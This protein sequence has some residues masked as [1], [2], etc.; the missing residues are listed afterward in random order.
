MK[1]NKEQPGFFPIIIEQVLNASVEKVWNAITNGEEMN[2]WY[3]KEMESFEPIVGFETQFSVFA[4]GVSYLHKWTVTEVVSLKKLSYEW[5]YPDYP[6]DSYIQ[7]ELT[8]ENGMTKLKF[9]HFGIESFPQ[10]S[11]DFSRESFTNGWNYIIGKSLKEFLEIE[12]E[13]NSKSDSVSNY[14]I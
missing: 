7:F 1:T 13:S 2:I 5:K 4:N 3:F 14:E 12:K 6:G 11:H 8:D 9:S 10:D